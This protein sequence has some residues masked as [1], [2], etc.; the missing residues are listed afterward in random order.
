MRQCISE[1]RTAADG[2][3]TCAV[4]STNNLRAHILSHLPSSAPALSSNCHT[5]SNIHQPHRRTH[6]DNAHLSHSRPHA[7]NLITPSLVVYAGTLW[8]ARYIQ[9]EPSSQEAETWVLEPGED[10]KWAEYAEEEEG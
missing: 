7:Q 4:T 8:A 6:I 5:L 1:A 2:C 10:E 9:P 3:E